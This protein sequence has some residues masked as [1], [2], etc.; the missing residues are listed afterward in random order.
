[1]TCIFEGPPDQTNQ[2]KGLQNP[3]PNILFGK[4]D[5]H[6]AAKIEPGRR[7]HGSVGCMLAQGSGGSKSQQTNKKSFFVF[8]RRQAL[9]KSV[10]FELHIKVWTICNLTHSHDIAPQ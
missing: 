7:Q 2:S 3:V 9:H 10:S 5:T 8:L 1:M 4:L 6:L